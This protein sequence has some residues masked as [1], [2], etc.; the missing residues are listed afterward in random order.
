MIV[1]ICVFWF[2]KVGEIGVLIF[3]YSSSLLRHLCETFSVARQHV[4]SINNQAQ[5][6]MNMPSFQKHGSKQGRSYQNVL[7]IYCIL[8]VLLS[9]FICLNC[10]AS[11]FRTECRDTGSRTTHN[12]FSD[13]N[14]SLNPV[15]S[16]SDR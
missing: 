1:F 4:A 11:Q 14:S 2:F 15:R 7:C 10:A 6:A 9:V 13:A 5:V 12:G 3:G 16:S 8:S